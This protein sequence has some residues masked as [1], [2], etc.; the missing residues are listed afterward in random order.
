MLKIVTRSLTPL[1]GPQDERQTY[2]RAGTDY[3]RL[4]VCSGPKGPVETLGVINEP[5]VWVIN[6]INGVAQHMVDHGKV[7]SARAPI[8][9]DLAQSAASPILQLEYGHEFEFFQKHGAKLLPP[10]VIDGTKVDRYSLVVDG[11]TLTLTTRPGSKIPWR[12]G[13]LMGRNP[14]QL[15]YVSF[16][17]DMPFQPELF[18]VPRKVKI[19]EAKKASAE[20]EPK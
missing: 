10:A 5:D 18:K 19:I 20:D 6:N 1:R 11:V 3:F 15:E 7:P 16:Q 13:Y 4:D 9:A 17:P 8:F 14:V 2:W 12:I